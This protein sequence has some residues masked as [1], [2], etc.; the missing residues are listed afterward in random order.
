ML[1]CQKIDGFHDASFRSWIQQKIEKFQKIERNNMNNS[2][3]SRTQTAINF[4][5]KTGRL[6]TARSRV[7]GNLL[8]TDWCYTESWILLIELY[9]GRST[10][11]NHTSSE[12]Q[13]KAAAP[14]H[15]NQIGLFD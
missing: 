14:A 13:K 2:M 10:E 4:Y 11:P 1:C 12:A 8:V 3:G 5:P 9:I 15:F 7:Q 6:C